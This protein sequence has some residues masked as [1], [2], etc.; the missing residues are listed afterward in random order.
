VLCCTADCT[1]AAEAIECDGPLSFSLCSNCRRWMRWG[2][3]A[4]LSLCCV[5][6]GRAGY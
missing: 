6:F 1:V 5:R 3:S 2:T 4:S